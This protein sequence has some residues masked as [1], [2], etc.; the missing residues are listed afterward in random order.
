MFLIIYI[1]GSL[2]QQTYLRDVANLFIPP[3]G[4]RFQYTIN[5]PCTLLRL[6]EFIA[7]YSGTSILLASEEISQLHEY[8]NCQLV[9]PKYFK[10][11]FQPHRR[12]LLSITKISLLVLYVEVVFIVE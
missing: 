1:N 8:N 2:R 5:W 10:I 6:S 11:K 9:L 7:L 4:P 3:P 12:Q